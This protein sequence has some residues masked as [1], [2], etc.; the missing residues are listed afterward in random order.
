MR[1]SRLPVRDG[2]L[3]TVWEVAAILLGSVLF[4]GRGPV[5]H[6]PRSEVS[7]GAAAKETLLNWAK[8]GRSE[9][10]AIGQLPDSASDFYSWEGGDAKANTVY[11]SFACNSREDCEKALEF[12]SAAR[13]DQFLRWS[14]SRYAT[15]MEGPAFYD[16]R[17][18]TTAWDL[19]RIE[20]GLV[21]EVVADRGMVL[22]YY[23]ADLARRR[24]YFHYA[25]YGFRQDRYRPKP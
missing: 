17:L 22:L 13:R 16:A 18:R 2:T 3:A 7:S 8:A 9:R 19:K 14:A 23:A 24:V 1:W 20:D 4:S 11:A 6:D 5:E 25:G 21:R 10:E 12:L 15:V